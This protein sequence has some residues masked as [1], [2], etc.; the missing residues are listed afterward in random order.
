[1][2]FDNVNEKT[3]QKQIESIRDAVD[4]LK[5]ARE[6]A[7]KYTGLVTLQVSDITRLLTVLDESANSLETILRI[8]KI[9]S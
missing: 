3:Y 2:T 8:K 1:M 5:V 6:Y 9:V 4:F 7:N